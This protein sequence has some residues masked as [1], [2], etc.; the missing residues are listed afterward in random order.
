[1]QNIFTCMIAGIEKS[2]YKGG[3]KMNFEEK[4]GYEFKN[5]KL[6]ELALTHT[7]YANQLKGVPSNERIEFLGDAVLEVIAS[8]YIYLTYPQLS[9]GE[10]TK[11]RAYSVCEES[12]AE[13][14]KKYGFSDVLHVGKSEQKI[15][16]LYRDSMLADSVEAVMGAI[17]LDAGIEEVKKFILP[18]IQ[19]KVR[20]FDLKGNNDYKTKLQEKLQVHGEV[21]IEYKLIESTGPDHD[22]TF[23]SEVLCDGKLLGKGKGKSKKEA[24]M[25]AAKEALNIN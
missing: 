15:N 3:G 7:S 2:F 6:L 23:V 25:E 14:A 19:N 11:M 24:E 17:F 13:V 21:K 22:K 10:M 4:I 5:K 12:L 16:G 20:Q 8:E 1:M 18:H 9:E